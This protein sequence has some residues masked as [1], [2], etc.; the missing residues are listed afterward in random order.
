MCSSDRSYS[1]IERARTSS[2]DRAAAFHVEPSYG[3]AAAEITAAAHLFL[4]TVYESLIPASMVRERLCT[5]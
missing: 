1:P 4:Q 3:S 5:L 2:V